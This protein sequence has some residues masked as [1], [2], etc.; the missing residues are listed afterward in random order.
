MSRCNSVKVRSY[1][2]RAGPDPMTGTLM[3]RGKSGAERGREACVRKP[4]RREWPAT[5]EA[6]RGRRERG[7]VHTWTADLGPPDCGRTHFW[8]SECPLP[9]RLSPTSLGLG[10]LLSKPWGNSY[11]V[12]GT[13]VSRIPRSSLL[14]SRGP[15][16]QLGQMAWGTG[17][18]CHIPRVPF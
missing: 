10:S 5:P 18:L 16:G 1:W 15:W 2:T 6:G 3:R 7:P 14:L 4:G 17:G 8:S 13:Q 11:L 9:R 12:T